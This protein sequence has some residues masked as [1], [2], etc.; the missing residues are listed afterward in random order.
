MLSSSGSVF[1]LFGRKELFNNTQ[2]SKK[3]N[4]IAKIDLISLN[5]HDKINAQN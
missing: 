3:V 2:I 5:I 1:I 4:K